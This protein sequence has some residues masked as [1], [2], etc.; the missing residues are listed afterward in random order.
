MTTGVG[1]HSFL[2]R[3]FPPC[4]VES[5]SPSLQAIS[6]PSEA[7]DK[8]YFLADANVIFKEWALW[9]FR[10]IEYLRGFSLPGHNGREGGRKRER[11]CVCVQ[12]HELW[13]EN[14]VRISWRAFL[15]LHSGILRSPQGTK[16]EKG[17]WNKKAF[18]E[19]CALIFQRKLEAQKSGSHLPSDTQLSWWQPHWKGLKLLSDCSETFSPPEVYI[20]PSVSEARF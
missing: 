2:Q 5:V 16:N 13:R 6:L 18:L 11:M 12:V 8:S 10:N 7:P 1:S 9:P 3:P 19:T 15:K 14:C 20:S 4:E 17:K